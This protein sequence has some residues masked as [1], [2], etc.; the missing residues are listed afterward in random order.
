VQAKNFPRSALAASCFE[1]SFLLGK[2]VS[3]RIQEAS[4]SNCALI[5]ASHRYAGKKFRKCSERYL[6]ATHIE[7]SRQVS[8]TWQ[9]NKLP[10]GEKSFSD[11]TRPQELKSRF[12]ELQVETNIQSKNTDNFCFSIKAAG[13]CKPIHRDERYSIHHPAFKTV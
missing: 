8:F 3:E 7:K 10:Q 1:L 6:I 12:Q 13:I 4:A 2:R 11:L 9:F 5:V